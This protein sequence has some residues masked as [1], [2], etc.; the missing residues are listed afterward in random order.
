[1]H[2]YLVIL[3][4]DVA[5]GTDDFGV[6]LSHEGFKNLIEGFVLIFGEIII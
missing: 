1:L 2:E 3:A 5:M 4:L 6:E